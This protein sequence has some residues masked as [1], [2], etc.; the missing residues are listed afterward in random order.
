M[1][2][3]KGPDLAVQVARTLGR[4]LTLAGPLEEFFHQAIEPYLDDRIRYVGVVDHRK[5]VELLG[6]AGCVLVPSRCE[7]GFG[8]VSIESMACGTP[9]VALANGALPEVIESGLTGYT[10]KDEQ[11][12]ATLVTQAMRLDRAAIRDRVTTRF[13]LRT[14]AD[15]YHRLYEQIA[16]ARADLSRRA[17]RQISPGKH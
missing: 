8:M 17:S 6:Q 7:E 10:T 12:L 3:D 11:A 5:K 13:D 1:G 15:Q 9:V 2:Q 16:G 14:I 4:P